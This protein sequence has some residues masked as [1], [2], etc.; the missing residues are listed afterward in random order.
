MKKIKSTYK[1][2]V[3]LLCIILCVLLAAGSLAG[4]IYSL[5]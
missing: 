4:I 5:F 3:R 2:W 1:P